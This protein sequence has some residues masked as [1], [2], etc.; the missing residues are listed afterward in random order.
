MNKIRKWKLTILIPSL[1][2]LIYCVLSVLALTSL[3]D[4]TPGD[5]EDVNLQGCKIGPISLIQLA[6]LIPAALVNGAWFL[7]LEKVGLEK[8]FIVFPNWLHLLLWQAILLG[9]VGN[10]FDRLIA[11]GKL[12]YK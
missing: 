12:R 2:L 7:F 6:T 9:L 3:N 10:I 5:P 8:I 4:C 11:F 1:F